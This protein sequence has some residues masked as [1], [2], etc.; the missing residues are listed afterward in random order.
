LWF[1]HYFP[2]MLL[3]FL[4]PAEGALL[5]FP[6][7]AKEAKGGSL[8]FRLP[9]HARLQDEAPQKPAF[10]RRLTGARAVF[11]RGVSI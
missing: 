11:L 9:E 6:L 4:S 10:R 5:L 8:P 2:F 3:R 1:W 7:P